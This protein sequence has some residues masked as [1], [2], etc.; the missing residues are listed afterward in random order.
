MRKSYT[1]PLVSVDIL[2]GE[3]KRAAVF[4]VWV[5]LTWP[6]LSY[7]DLFCTND[8]NG[9]NTQ[10]D[11]ADQHQYVVIGSFGRWKTTP[12]YQIR[13]IS[14]GWLSNYLNAPLLKSDLL[15]HF[16]SAFDNRTDGS[17]RH[18]K[19]S[20]LTRVLVFFFL[21]L[22]EV[23]LSSFR[24][25]VSRYCTCTQTTILT[26]ALTCQ[27]VSKSLCHAR[28]SFGSYCSVMFPRWYA[29]FL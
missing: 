29:V 3:R 19:L 24:S 13:Q 17:F 25:H 27:S 12:R 1:L 5:H 11:V 28:Y 26:V 10:I 9:R 8:E 16:L 20:N 22:E 18:L 21:V 15:D 4:F 6:T 7:R 2:S 14:D 23:I